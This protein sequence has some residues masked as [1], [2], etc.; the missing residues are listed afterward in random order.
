MLDLLLHLVASDTVCVKE[1]A[2]IR[3]DKTLD[4]EVRP[5]PPILNALDGG[6]NSA[7][8]PH[9]VASEIKFLALEVGDLQTQFLD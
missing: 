3:H 7:Q 4:V 6:R 9:F 1:L 2:E 5:G 8:N